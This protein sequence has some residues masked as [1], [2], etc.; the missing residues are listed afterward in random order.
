MTYT[1][2]DIWRISEALLETGRILPL[3]REKK[4]YYWDW[5]EVKDKSAGLENSIMSP[6]LMAAIPCGPYSLLPVFWH[7]L[8]VF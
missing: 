4:Y 5:F 2:A 6:L 1:F 3:K 7:L 8:S